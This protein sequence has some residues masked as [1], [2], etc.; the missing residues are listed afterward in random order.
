LNGSDG[1]FGLRDEEAQPGRGI[2]NSSREGQA[3]EVRYS[4][5]KAGV[6]RG[7]VKKAIKHVGS[8]RKKIEDVLKG[9]ARLI[10]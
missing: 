1:S 2:E 4:S 5:R 10:D 7:A 9:R 3:H 8:S 6:K